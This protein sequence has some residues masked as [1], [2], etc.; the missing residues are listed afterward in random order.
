M[1]GPGT[2]GTAH[3]NGR[4]GADEAHANGGEPSSGSP[5]L[6]GRAVRGVGRVGLGGLRGRP[7]EDETRISSPFLKIPGSSRLRTL[8]D[9]LWLNFGGT[10]AEPFVDSVQR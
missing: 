9:G 6:L 3:G 2:A 10:F 7:A 4:V 1:A 5:S 8:P